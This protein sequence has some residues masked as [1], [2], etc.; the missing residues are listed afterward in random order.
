MILTKLAVHGVTI[1]MVKTFT[2]NVT[3]SEMANLR[4]AWKIDE[5]HYRVFGRDGD[6]YVVFIVV[7]NKVIIVIACPCQAGSFGN[8]CF[9]KTVVTRRLLREKQIV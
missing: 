6:S 3:S 9:H 1:K 8:P 2:K 4:H 5:N 7:D